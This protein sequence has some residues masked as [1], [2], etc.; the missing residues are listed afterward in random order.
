MLFDFI[1]TN[2]D[3]YIPHSEQDLYAKR[4]FYWML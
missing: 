2:I 1:N 4:I 3:P